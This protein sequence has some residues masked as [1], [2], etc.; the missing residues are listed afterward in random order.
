MRKRL[1]YVLSAVLL[2]ALPAWAQQPPQ[3]T[4]E[5]E[6]RAELARMQ[7]QIARTEALLGRLEEELRATERP[8]QAGTSPPES[9]PVKQAPALNTPPRLPPSG[10]EAFR[11]TPPRFDV[12]IQTRGDYFADPSQGD[13]ALRKALGRGRD[14]DYLDYFIRVK[15]DEWTRYHEQVTPWE[16]KEYLTRF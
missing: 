15:R 8:Q 16:I 3:S 9:A 5:G 14:E 11:K 10:A 13:D 4:L 12:L 2:L 6:L 7:A 1:P